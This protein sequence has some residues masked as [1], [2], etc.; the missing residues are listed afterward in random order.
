MTVG[1]ECIIGRL[2]RDRPHLNPAIGERSQLKER[3][4]MARDSAQDGAIGIVLR[5]MARADK[6]AAL[7]HPG[8]RA[9]HMRARGGYRVDGALRLRV[10]HEALHGTSTEPSSLAWR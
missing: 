3:E 1:H 10:D 9:A 8:D 4:R 5:A 2:R 7:P 6:G